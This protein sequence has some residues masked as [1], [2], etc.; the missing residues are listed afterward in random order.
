LDAN[1][2]LALGILMLEETEHAVTP[3]Q[4]QTLLPLWQALQGGVTAED[5]IAAV[6][7]GIEGA[8]SEE[9]L[10]T[11]GETTLT[12][13]NLE[14]WMEEQ[15]WTGRQGLAGGQGEADGAAGQGQLGQRGARDGGG[16][17][18][19][20][21][22]PPERATRIAELQSMSEEER[23]AMMATARA[24]GG[25]GAGFRGGPSQEPDAAVVGA[26]QLR[27]VLRPLITLLESRAATAGS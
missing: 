20:E 8:L 18:S 1:A 23:E 25:M 3:D 11:I 21:D 12:Q 16:V 24:G 15:G 7:R 2:Q 22:V 19:G 10:A 5:E 17:S 9:Q 26:G 13:A 4:A 27:F 14:A 6:L